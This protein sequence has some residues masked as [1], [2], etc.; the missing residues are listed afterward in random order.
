MF[1]IQSNDRHN[2]SCIG[3]FGQ[4]DHQRYWT[5]WYSENEPYIYN[6]TCSDFIWTISVL[7]FCSHKN[8]GNSEI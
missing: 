2:I 3:L 6:F 8:Q 1:V 4:P 7:G 5:W